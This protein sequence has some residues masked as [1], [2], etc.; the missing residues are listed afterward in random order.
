MEEQKQ[1]QRSWQRSN[2][3]RNKCNDGGADNDEGATIRVVIE[4]LKPCA[5]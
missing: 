3:W 4:V 2:R 1:R 5:F